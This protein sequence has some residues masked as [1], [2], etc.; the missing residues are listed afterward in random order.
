MKYHHNQA[1]NDTILTTC[2]N[3]QP[4]KEVKYSKK[5]YHKLFNGNG[6][7]SFSLLNKSTSFL[8]KYKL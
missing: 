3:G 7:K 4:I 2:Y 5:D 8:A 1:E 6:I